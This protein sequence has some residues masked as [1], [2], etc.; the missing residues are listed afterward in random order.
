MADLARWTL[1]EP[2][3]R[4]HDVRVTRALFGTR[5]VLDRRAVPRFDRSAQSDRYALTLAGHMVNVMVPPATSGEPMLTVDGREAIGSEIALVTA[6]VQGA[7]GAAPI[8]GQDFARY[9][10]LQRRNTGGAWFYWIAGASVLNSVLY[11]AR[12]DWA[13]FIGLGITQLIDG[14]AIALSGTVRT[15]VYAII[16]DVLVAAGFFLFGRAAR[17]G[18]LGIFAVGIVLYA[19]D[20]LIFIWAEDWLALAFHGFV[21]F[22][23]I[24]GWRAAR[25]L[26]KLDSVRTAA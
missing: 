11:A 22:G 24:N 14:L 6:E 18:R 4:K 25:A 19:L 26:G 7:S 9:Q 20:G 12:I 1:S 15:P 23:L 5:V 16:I 17:A 10:L 8:T 21:V 3:G 2:S 13:L